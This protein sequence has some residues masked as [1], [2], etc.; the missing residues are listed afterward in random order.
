MLSYINTGKEG[1]KTGRE[2]GTEGPREGEGIIDYT[3]FYKETWS[4]LLQNLR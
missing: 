4:K 1:R 2:G 3:I